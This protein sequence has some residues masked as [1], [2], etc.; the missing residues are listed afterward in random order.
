MR[1]GSSM[2]F[3][4]P[5]RYFARVTRIHPRADLVNCGFF[6]MLIDMDNTILSRATKD[7]PIDVRTWLGEVR[8]A[9]VK[10][11]LL[12]NNWHETPYEWGERLDIPVVGK[13]CKPLPYGYLAARHV[14]GATSSDTV[15]VGDQL[16]T[17]VVGAHLLGMAAYLVC[18]L[19][20]QDLLRIRAVRVLERMALGA[21]VPE[22]AQMCD[23]PVVES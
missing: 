17:D 7:I 20:E 6:H 4:E 9:G 23:A 5:E 12:S 11:C 22:G 16:S 14:L 3:L 15:V 2:A 10:V 13:A 18:P 1:K 19:A 8:E 21:R